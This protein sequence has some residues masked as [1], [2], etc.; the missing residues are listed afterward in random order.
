[1]DFDIALVLV[2]LTFVSGFIWIL[3]KFLWEKDRQ[4][5]Q[6]AEISS[7]G[8]DISAQER[9]ALLADPV[10]I[11]YAK[12]LFPV[13]FIVL[14]LRSFIFEPFRIPSQSMMP[15][16]WV[17]DFILVNKFSYGVRLPVLNTEIIDSGK[18]EN[19]DVAVFRYPVNPAINFIKRVIGIPGDHVV[20]R[21]KLLYLNGKPMLQESL[22]PYKGMGSGEKMNG[23]SLKKENLQGVSHDILLVP[24]KPDL[25]HMYFPEFYNNSTIDLV[26]PEGHYFV[27]G[28]NRDESHDGRFWGLVPEANLVGKAFMIWFNWDVGQGLFWERIGNSIE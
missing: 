25:S 22:G 16:L 7:K 12:S 3:D 9:D 6:Q 17:G 28:D 13:F 24:G 4:A 15:N 19:G 2:V 26:V 18:P 1:M 10:I 21:N 11:D 5:K 20:Y 23:A 27:M 8:K 14:I